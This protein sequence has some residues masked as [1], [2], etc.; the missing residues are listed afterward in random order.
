MSENVTTIVA[1][2]ESVEYRDIPGFPGYRV[3]NDGS[4]WSRHVPRGP[5]SCLTDKWRPLKPALRNG[6]PFV[7]LFRAGRHQFNV[8]RLV[9]LAFVGPCPPGM[10]CCHNDGN[11]RNSWLSNLRWDTKAENGRDR[12]RHQSMPRGDAHHKSK[13]TTAAIRRMITDYLAGST[14]KSELARRHGMS[15]DTVSNATRGKTWRH[16]WVEFNPQ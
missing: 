1:N 15:R 12:V 2:G 4:V 7:A 13:T 8:C 6:Y 3:G 14:N 9:L 16:V 5:K 11:R 10:E